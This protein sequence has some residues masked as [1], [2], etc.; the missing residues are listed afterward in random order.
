MTSFRPDAK[1]DKKILI[2]GNLSVILYKMV[3]FDKILSL[4]NPHEKNLCRVQFLFAMT[5]WK[6]S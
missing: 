2:K 6:S 4:F 3:F 5:R 1:G